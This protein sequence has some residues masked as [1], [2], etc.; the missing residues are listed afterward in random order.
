[1]AVATERPHLLERAGVLDGLRKRLDEARAGRGSLVLIAGEAGVGKSAAV[2]DFCADSGGARVLAGGCDALFTP[3]PL[4]PFLDIAEEAEELRAALDGGAAE[5]V[6]ALLRLIAP[7]EATIVVLE[8]VHWADE[9]TLDTLRL[10]ARRVGQFPLLVVAT[11]R[12]DELDRAHPL[13]VVVGELATRTEV[14]RLSV[15]PLSRVP[16][17][18]WPHRARST[19]SSSTG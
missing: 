7:G 12:D 9:A 1:M 13:R 17:P 3:R 19:L 4:G 18:S 14:Q 8:D 16:S 10:L 5:V 15:S 2:R 11:Y 6:G